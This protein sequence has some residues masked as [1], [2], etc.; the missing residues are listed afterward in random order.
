MRAANVLA[1]MQETLAAVKDGR[2][3]TYNDV[4]SIVKP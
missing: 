2:I 1:S 3:R 4:F